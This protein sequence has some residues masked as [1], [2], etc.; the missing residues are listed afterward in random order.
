MKPTQLIGVLAAILVLGTTVAGAQEPFDKK[1]MASQMRRNQEELRNY[2]WE[3]KIVFE[4]N[5]KTRRVDHYTVRYVMGGM[6]ERMQINSKV[7]KEPLRGPDGK[8]LKKKQLEAAREFA[9]GVKKQVDAYLNPLFAEKIVAMATVTTAD[10]LHTLR[11]RD[12]VTPGDAVEVT[13]SEATKLPK[14]MKVAT[15]TDGSP[16]GL[17]IEFGS[18]DYGPNYSAHSI[19]TSNWQGIKLT[20]ITENSNYEAQRR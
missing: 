3:S 15:T 9:M 8:K 10:G 17:E 6:L 1:K 18:I 16:A 2:S 12:V 14:T 13:F 7:E 4:V 19:T 11:S 20:I 5:D